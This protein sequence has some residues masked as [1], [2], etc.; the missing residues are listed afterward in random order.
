MEGL[1]LF[2]NRE[3]GW[4]KIGISKNIDQR[5][6]QIAKGLPFPL[7]RIRCWICNRDSPEIAESSLH[8]RFKEKR[9]RGEWFAF[10]PEDLQEL[11]AVMKRGSK[12]CPKYEIWN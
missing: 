1:Y 12:W 6:R 5:F 8:S 9:L 7:E 4:Y 11:F 2:G 10:S 3:L